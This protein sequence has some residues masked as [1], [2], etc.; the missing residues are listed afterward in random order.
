MTDIKLTS[1]QILVL[2]NIRDHGFH[3]ATGFIGAS[4]RGGAVK[5]VDSL[6]RRGLV[7][8]PHRSEHLTEEGQRV[9]GELE[10]AKFGMTNAV[11]R[12]L[13]TAGFTEARGD[14][15][16]GFRAVPGLPG[17]VR[18]SYVPKPHETT[19]RVSNEVISKYVRI[20]QSKGFRVSRVNGVT[21]ADRLLVL[22][23]SAQP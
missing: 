5:S 17:V 4:Q 8:G 21:V 6:R 7:D 2:R 1:A 13:Y 11:R 3:A 15:T 19:L 18:L 22:Q 14:S 16:W 20:L 12:V 23:E 9:L 10:E